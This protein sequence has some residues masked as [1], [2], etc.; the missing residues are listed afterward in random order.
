MLFE[1]NMNNNGME[2]NYILVL[3]VLLHILMIYLHMAYNCIYFPIS[4]TYC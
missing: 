4:D 3:F 1:F 2:F